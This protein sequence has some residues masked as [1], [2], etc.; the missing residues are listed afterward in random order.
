MPIFREQGNIGKYFKEQGTETN[1]W[2]LENIELL[3][4]T[5]REQG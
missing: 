5:F 1:F 3:K 4:I 2:E